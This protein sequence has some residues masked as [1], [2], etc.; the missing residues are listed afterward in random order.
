MKSGR[1]TLYIYYHG[2]NHP[3]TIDRDSVEDLDKW[4]QN[5]RNIKNFKN[6]NKWLIMDGTEEVKS[7]TVTV[8]EIIEIR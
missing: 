2:T 7:G 3:M 6:S 1:Y 4:M 5:N 8:K